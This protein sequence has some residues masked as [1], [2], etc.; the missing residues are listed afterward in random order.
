MVDHLLNIKSKFPIRF[1]TTSRMLI[2]YA[3]NLALKE[4]KE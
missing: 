4:A 3:R 2:D 1:L